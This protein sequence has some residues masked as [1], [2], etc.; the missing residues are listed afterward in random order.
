MGRSL[1]NDE[2]RAETVA[3]LGSPLGE[4][5]HSLEN[6]LVWVH[7]KWQEY[8]QLFGDSQQR[9]DLLNSTAPAFFH[10]LQRALWEDI[11]LH[12]CRLTDKLKSAGKPTLTLRQLAPAGL[13]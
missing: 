5:F 6:Q 9:V 10:E 8:L 2:V 11:L 7:L 4:L 12:L 3:A 1:T 13:A